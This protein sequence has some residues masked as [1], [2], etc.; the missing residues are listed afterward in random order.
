MDQMAMPQAQEDSLLASELALK[1]S[2]TPILH[3]SNSNSSNSPARMHSLNSGGMN[4]GG[5]NGGG[6]NG[7]GSST[8]LSL[9]QP[10]MRMTSQLNGSAPLYHR[11]DSQLL[12]HQASSSLSDQH[13]DEG[14]SR[15]APVSTSCVAPA[16]G[17]GDWHVFL[18]HYQANAG[19]T[20][21]SLKLILEQACQGLRCWYDN[22]QDPSESGMRQGVGNSRWVYAVYACVLDTHASCVSHS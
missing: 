19:N 13:S 20:V 9:R 22:D 16:L 4:S 15:S 18:S 6:M 12:M 1:L 14:G 10:M 2:A 5:M 8:S 7:G 3:P 11:S 21:F 17:A